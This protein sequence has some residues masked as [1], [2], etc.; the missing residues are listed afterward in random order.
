MPITYTQFQPGFGVPNLSSFCMKG[1]ILLKMAN[2]EYQSDILDDPRKAPKGKLPFL[3]DKG[4]EIADTSFI[5]GHLE[6]E[7][8]I[9]FDPGLSDIEK[10][11]SHAMARMVEERLYWVM[12]YSRWMDDKNWLLI[13]D[14]WFGGM[15]VIVRSLVPMVALKQVKTAL[16]GHGLG[17]HS[18]EDI[19]KFGA[20]DLAALSQQL[21][22]KSYMFGDTPTS[23]DAVAYP[24]I[25]NCLIEKLPGPLLDTAKSHENFPAYVERCQKLWFPDI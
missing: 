17:R 6:Q 19:Y 20:E 7:Y 24:V 8:G 11:V 9:D 21:G 3:V 25:L 16:H 14:F 15:P 18:A 13:K 5:R 12:L 1:E 10:A 2:L 4:V 23:L 22:E